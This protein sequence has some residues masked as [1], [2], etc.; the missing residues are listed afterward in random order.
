MFSPLLDG[1]YTRL[2]TKFLVLV[3]F[4]NYF[5]HLLNNQ[6]VR[7][8]EGKVGMEVWGCEE[9]PQALPLPPVA[10]CLPQAG[11]TSDA[12]SVGGGTEH[13]LEGGFRLAGSILNSSIHWRMSQ[14]F[15]TISNLPSCWTGM[16]EQ[17]TQTYVM[18]L[19]LRRLEFYYSLLIKN[20]ITKYV[21]T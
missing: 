3:V 6:L 12:A 7:D 13:L 14:L 17:Q 1:S 16:L 9:V 11:G 21:H 5:L 10:A 8:P 18:L 2:S 19:A 15:G 4:N 20:N